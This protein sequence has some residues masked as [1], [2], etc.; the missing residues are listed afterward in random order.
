MERIS[1]HIRLPI[2]LHAA[3]MAEAEHM[4]I[5]LNAMVTIAL[6]QWLALEED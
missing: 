4:G 6:R 1:A 2:D 5:S 3:L